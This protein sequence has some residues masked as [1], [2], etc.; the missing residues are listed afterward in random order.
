MGYYVDT[1]DYAVKNAKR[2]IALRKKLDAVNKAIDNPQIKEAMEAIANLKMSLKKQDAMA[3]AAKQIT[4]SVVAFAVLNDG[5]S[6]EG[7][8]PLL[9]KDTDYR[10]AK[11][12]TQ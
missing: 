7:V 5:S 9:A 6:L 4:A 3:I 10:G 2:F 8:D 12:G 11:P 1:G